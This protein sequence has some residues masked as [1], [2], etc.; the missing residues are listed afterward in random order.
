[1]IGFDFISTIGEEAQDS[2]ND[3]PVAMYQTVVI[4][5]LINSLVAFAMCGMGMG[6]VNTKSPSTAMAD[7]FETVGYQW[8]QYII[9]VCA[10]LGLSASMLTNFMAVVRVVQAFAREK[11]LPSF[12][13]KSNP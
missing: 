3:V 9:Y 10:V 11:F 6:K 13:A 1:M 2:R 5:T 8:V 7:T 12:L 4:C